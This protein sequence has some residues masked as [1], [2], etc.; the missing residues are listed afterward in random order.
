MM[1]VVGTSAV[2]A[3]ASHLPLLAKSSGAKVVE[4]NLELT[5]FSEHVS[6]YVFQ[7]NASTVPPALAQAL[8]KRLAGRS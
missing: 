6:D 3:P 2:V 4:S 8:E 7:K 1:L 5:T